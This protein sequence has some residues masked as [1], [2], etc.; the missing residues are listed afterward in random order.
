MNV[1]KFYGGGKFVIKYLLF[2]FKYLTFV[3]NR[4]L[5]HRCGLG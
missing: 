4:W 1:Q 5:C 2:G 3:K